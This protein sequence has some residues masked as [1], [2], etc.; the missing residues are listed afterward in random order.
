M[1][2]S[3]VKILRKGRTAK[4]FGT[5]GFKETKRR[6][7]RMSHIERG[8]LSAQLKSELRGESK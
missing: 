4:H 5:V 8:K 7:K 3:T 1:R 2:G 6:W